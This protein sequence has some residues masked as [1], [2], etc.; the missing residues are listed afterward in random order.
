MNIKNKS[1]RYAALIGCA[2]C[3][4]QALPF[5]TT[6]SQPQTVEVSEALLQTRPDVFKTKILFSKDEATA[7]APAVQ[8]IMEQ[9]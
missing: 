4:F 2:F 5:L 3:L 7:V 6:E 8:A 1:L 9:E